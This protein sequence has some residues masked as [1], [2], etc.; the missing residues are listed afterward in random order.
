LSDKEE[1]P[2][3]PEAGQGIIDITGFAFLPMWQLLI[4]PEKL[5]SQLITD[6]KILDI[7]SKNQ[8]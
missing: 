8:I 6:L 3:I 4:S 7:A 5:G 1:Q 2:I